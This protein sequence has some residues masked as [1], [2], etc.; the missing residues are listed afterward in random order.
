[1]IG[2]PLLAH[3]TAHKSGHGLNNLLL[4]ALL[5]QADAYDIVTFNDSQQAP[6]SYAHQVALE[7]ALE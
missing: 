5:E 3:F 2:H 7:W 6:H 1:L 4:R